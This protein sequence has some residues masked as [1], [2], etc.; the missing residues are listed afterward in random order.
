MAHNISLIC[1][2]LFGSIR[3]NLLTDT[4]DIELTV[5][6]VKGIYM[7][8]K[9]QTAESMIIL[10]RFLI[11]FKFSNND[12]RSNFLKEQN[13]NCSRPQGFT[14]VTYHG[15]FKCERKCYLNTQL[16]IVLENVIII[17]T[18]FPTGCWGNIFPHT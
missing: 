10:C 4:V 17:P 7:Y 18:Q 1:D 14:K 6:M 5:Q 12:T 16:E 8:R 2:I 13:Q 15:F 3:T 9:D 11:L